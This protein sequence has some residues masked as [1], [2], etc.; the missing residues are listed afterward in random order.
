MLQSYQQQVESGLLRFDEAQWQVLQQL[1][2]L[3]SQLDGAGPPPQGLY[4]YGPVGRGKT[5]LMDLFYHELATPQKIRLHFH[6]FMAR[7]HQELHQLSGQPEPLRI[8]AKHWAARYQILCFDEFFVTDIGDAMLLGTLWRELFALKVILVATS[9]SP[10]A[11][12]YANGLQRSR[13]LPTIAL[14]EQHCQLFALDHGIDYR[15]MQQHPMRFYLQ[16][17]AP[18]ELAALATTHFGPLQQDS[19][20]TSQ[21]RL[22]E[23]DI[24]C[25][26]RN[27]VIIGFDFMALF[28]GPRSQLDYMA[29]ANQFR[30]IAVANVPQFTKV[31][32]TAILHGV[33]ENYQREHQDIFV[34]KLDNEARRFIAL[35]D[36]CY[37]RQTLLLLSA[38]VAIIELYQAS[39]LSFAFERTISRLHEM[40]SWTPVNF[41]R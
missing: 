25:L 8:I 15:R 21:I 9:N 6:H 29:L 26:W 7:V 27:K 11:A 22:L 24:P 20:P 16:Q 13:F 37:E 35:V 14:L 12:L 38:E 32:D 5:M 17:P 40:Q 23:R 10:P 41:A 34:S 1:A 28:S 30:A 33:E 18:G 19:Q 39:Q 4:I 36:E 31:S 3:A 2:A